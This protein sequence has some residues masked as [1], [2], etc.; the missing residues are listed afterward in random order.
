MI[1]DRP[2]E[3]SPE[4]DCCSITHLFFVFLK[5]AFSDTMLEFID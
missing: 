2:D 3:R 5:K 4:W 1:D